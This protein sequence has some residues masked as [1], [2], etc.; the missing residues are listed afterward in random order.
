MKAHI[1]SFNKKSISSTIMNISINHQQ[2]YA[3]SVNAE[4]LNI[5]NQAQQKFWTDG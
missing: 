3:N 5:T 2:A 1:I 4:I